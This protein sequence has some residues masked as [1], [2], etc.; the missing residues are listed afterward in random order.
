M[1]VFTNDQIREIDR[2]T[3]ESEGVTSL[4]LIERVAEGVAAEVVSHLKANSRI[5]I[6][7]GP[8]NNGADALE[9][10]RI[11]RKSVV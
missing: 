6:F 4:Q 11:D 10:A 1:K 8:G 7:A 9:A 2:I 3:L 5:A